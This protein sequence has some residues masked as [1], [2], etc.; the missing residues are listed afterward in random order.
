VELLHESER[1]RVIRAWSDGGTVIRKEPLGVGGQQRLR[2]EVEILERLSGVE[3]VVR[4]ATGVPRS[5]GA[6]LLVDVAGRPLSERTSPLDPAELVELAGSLARAVAG[7][8]H[9]GVVHRDINPANVLVTEGEG[10]ACLID[11]A[12]ATTFTAV[13]PGFVHHSEIVGTLPYLAPE[14]TGRTARQVDQRADLYAVGATLYELATGAP[15]FGVD[16][17]LRIIHDHLTRVP[18]A[19]SV[20]NAAV[21]ADLS[22]IIMHLLEKEPDDRYQSADGLVRDL[23]LLRRGAVARPGEHDLPASPLT[24]S[25]L[26]GREEEIGELNLAF[27]EAVAGRCRGILVGGAA[28]VGK[29][30]LVNELRPVVAGE[31]GWFVAGKFDQF[32][33][34][35]EYDAVRQA[36]RALGRLLL[37]EP[38]EQLVELRERM[39]RALGPGAGLISAVVPELAALLRVPPELGDPMTAQA[40]LQRAAVDM[41]R[42]VASRKRPVVFFVDD[43]QWAGRTPLGFVDLLISGDEA[44]EGLL[45][46]GAYREEEVDS[47]HPLTPMLA[48][49][50]RQPGGL[51]H[52]QVDNL[53]P[54]GQA[55]MVADLLRLPAGRG[56]ELA[57]LIRPSTGANPYNTVELLHSLRRDGVLVAGDGGW[58]W[59]RPT[60][61]GRLERVDVT[62]L[63]VARAATLPPASRQVVRVMAC[64]A[65]RVELDLLEAATGLAADEVERRLAPACDAGL[66]VL[67]SDGQSSARFH[68]D[69]GQESVLGA[70]RP[71]VLRAERLRLARRLAGRDDF[72]SVAAEQY[73]P[74][75]DAVTE[76]AERQLIAKLLRRAAGDAGLVSDYQLVERY[77]T[78][79]V[80]LL[81]PAD[82]DGLITVH[83]GRHAALYG[84]GRL[85]EG[86]EV[87]RIIR[88]LCVSPVQRAAATV[89]QVRSLTSRVRLDEAIRLGL[90]ELRQLGLAVPDR[91]HL[92]AETDR[93]L[94]AVYQWINQ[95]GTSED[96]PRPRIIDRATSDTFRLADSLIAPTYFA[97]EPARD[98]LSVQALQTWA[99]DGPNPALLGPASH[100]AMVTSVRGRDYRTGYRILRRILAAARECG[101]ESEPDMWGMRFLYAVSAAPWFNP[102]E[103]IVPELRRVLEGFLQSG[104][105]PS[106]SWAHN[107]LVQDLLD[108]APSLDALVAQI[109]AGIAF[110]I[111][112]GN[113]MSEELLSPW[114]Q[115]ARVLRGEAAGPATDEPTALLAANP[116][117]ATFMRLTQALAAAIFDRPA[118]LAHH[119]KAL[120]LLPFLDAIYVEATAR[121]LQALSLAGQAR[122][123]TQP[124]RHEAALAELDEKIAWLSDHATDAPANFEHLLHLVEAERAWAGGDFREA[125]VAFDL[126]QCKVATRTRPWHRALILERAARFHLAHG[127]AA[128][129]S[130]LLAAARDQYQDWGATAKVSQLDWAYPTLRTQPTSAPPA[131]VPSA[132][133]P[134]AAVPSAAVPSAPARSAAPPVRRSTLATG[135][136]DWLGVVAAS[137]ALSAEIT[138]EGM[139]TRIVGILS[140]MT[141]ATSVHLLLRD[142]D[143]QDWSVLAGDASTVPLAEAG[144]RCLL[145]P[146]AVRY[147]ERTHEPLVVADATRDDRFQHDPYLTDL[148]RCALLAIPITIR[149]ELRAMLLLENRMIRGAFTTE[150]LEGIIL[151]AGQLAVSL[152]NAQI[153]ASL[154]HKVTE[155]TQQLATANQ[156]LEQLSLT[157]PMTG[158]A[159]RRRLDETLRAEW[160]RATRQRT[161]LAL[162]MIDID[163]FKL[164]NDHYGHTVGDRCLRQVAACL[165]ASTR[166]TDLAARYGGEE[167]AIVMPATDLD[168]ATHLAQHLRAAVAQL[169]E[170]HPLADNHIVTVSIGVTATTPTPHDDP[171][172]LVELADTAL[173]QAKDH[174]RNRVE[175][176]LPGTTPQ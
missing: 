119:T 142:Q 84:L 125:A 41:L 158:L 161:P 88:E 59:D 170:P 129:G 165:A 64:L 75:L 106:A 110:A 159:N 171:T 141:G 138:I 108:C 132:P 150:R 56:A 136:I 105:L 46:V 42:A 77:L 78:A 66:L 62:G 65:G 104:D 80:A 121:L 83:A 118:E 76:P 2:H 157:D 34:N 156:R 85:D 28:G 152:D 101:F 162:A 13:Q 6:I 123:T 147:A 20:V 86:D 133:V 154:E 73:L 90:D 60:L 11:F 155:R 5:P 54:E 16:D 22:A 140:A 39:L 18:V 33:R 17:P 126:A 148:E 98:W 169:A 153:Y 164:Y 47:A 87:Y 116:L 100:A 111:R 166:V 113:S 24:P 131:T 94:D 9:R 134:S 135:T 144:R 26:S 176:A 102:V 127:L 81:D 151:I 128:T 52:L 51:R 23:N 93:G 82:V 97:A 50:W 172:T 57:R 27:V 40:R 160:H 25:R 45:L 7:M 120:T 19:P 173:Y 36:F 38:E 35:Q 168:A 91:D 175:T 139:Q 3:G 58:R 130:T 14:Q 48:R 1:T 79:A 55:A 61:R 10:A 163:H 8:H 92:E 74:V 68:H 167:F 109:E 69:R 107:V 49:W 89:V 99:R 31:D 63:L 96:L 30:S 53:T 146:S 149:G 122:T 4:L 114:R 103:D 117:A 12:L 21:P 115:L 72:V 43:L 174:G 71:R 124:G 137:Q 143:Q 29:T 95:T 70:L 145:P 32:R 112:T 67:E 44:I 15:P 37:P